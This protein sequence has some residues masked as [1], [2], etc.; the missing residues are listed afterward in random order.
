MEV[1]SKHVLS[2]MQ[3]MPWKALAFTELATKEKL[4]STFGVRGI[5]TLVLLNGRGETLTKDGRTAIM[6]TPF[7]Q[8]LHYLR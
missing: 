7:E 4:S 6:H 8:L 2:I 3:A 5:P 1:T